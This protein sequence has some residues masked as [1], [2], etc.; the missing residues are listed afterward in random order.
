[1]SAPA[2]PQQDGQSYPRLIELIQRLLAPDGCPWDREQSIESLKAHLLEE[3]SEVVDAIDGGDREALCEELG[4]VLMQVVFLGELARQEGAFGPDDVIAGIVDKLVRRH[5]H[6]FGEQSVAG[7]AQVLQNWER[8]KAGERR[9]QGKQ[10]GMLD[11]VPRSL[12]ALARAQRMGD[13]V[14]RVGFDWPDIGGCHA[15][16]HEELGELE[17]AMAEAEHAGVEEELGDVLF[18]LCNLARHLHVDAEGALRKTTGKFARRFGQV[19]RQVA[20]RH[21]G[22]PTG[23]E[24]LAIEELDR[25]WEQ[26]KRDER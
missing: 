8:I 10:Q 11:S 9:A 16:V 4:D 7:S 22:W 6:V 18:A 17:A 12:S 19:E 23:G 13:R 15:K 1:M 2:L 3:A 26:A 25:Y 5:P 21:G 24:P 20:A 14:A